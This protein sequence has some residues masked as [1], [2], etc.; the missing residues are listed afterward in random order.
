MATKA[1]QRAIPT[2]TVAIDDLRLNEETEAS[3]VARHVGASDRTI[4]RCGHEEIV[5]TYPELIAAA[6][7]PVI[8]TSCASLVL[9]ARRVN[10]SGYKVALTG[11]GSDEWLA[12]YPWFRMHKL[13][14]LLDAVP[15]LRL[16]L[17]LPR[18]VLKLAG[19]PSFPWNTVRRAEH[20]LGGP[21]PWLLPYGLLSNNKLRFFSADMWERLDGHEPYAEIPL[22]RDRMARWH[23]AH[24]AVIIGAR[25]M[26]PGFLLASKGD[27]IAMLSSVEARYPFLDEDLFEFLATLHPSWKLRGLQDKY[28]LRRVAQRW[29][30]RRVAW[31]RKVMFRAPLDSFHR[32]TMGVRVPGAEWV[33][34]VL[35]PQALRRAGY[36]DPAAVTAARQRAAR[37]QRGSLRHAGEALG[38]TAVLATQ[39]WH[40]TYIDRNVIPLTHG[41]PLAV[42]A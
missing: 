36:F 32:K 6:E 5:A 23:P 1:V 22:P 41:E 26:L 9:L 35:S 37:G 21:S 38:L 15:R 20:A 33:D 29:L 7:A 19:V 2:F 10:E 4:V 24:R 34:D 17:R 11:E 25:V 30:P 28:L 42:G 12:G 31:R 40:H 18:A 39:L 13:L 14:R 8:D 3:L 16:S 27:R